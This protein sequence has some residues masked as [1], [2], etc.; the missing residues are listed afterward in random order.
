MRFLIKVM[1]LIAVLISIIFVVTA[2]TLALGA[3]LMRLFPLSLFQAALLLSASAG[4]TIFAALTVCI[5]HYTA[6]E[7]QFLCDDCRNNNLADTGASR[8]NIRR[9]DPCPCGS[10]KKFKNCCGS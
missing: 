2:A 4:L 5:M 6:E 9:N 1:A 10:G 7:E 3:A 8:E